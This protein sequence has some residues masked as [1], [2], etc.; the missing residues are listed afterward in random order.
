[1][2]LPASQGGLVVALVAAAASGPFNQGIYNGVIRSGPGIATALPFLPQKDFNRFLRATAE[3]A[4]PDTTVYPLIQF[5]A[6]PTAGSGPSFALP[7]DGSSGTIDGAVVYS[8]AAVGVDLREDQGPLDMR[9]SAADLVFAT[10]GSARR[11]RL[12]VLPVDRL[13]NPADPPAGLAVTVRVTPP[14]Q[15]AQPGPV[16]AEKGLSLLTAKG[17]RVTLK[18][19]AASASG[20][21]GVVTAERDGVVVA[22][23]SY[24]IDTRSNRPQPDVVVPGGNVPTIQ[25]AIEGASDDN[26]DGLIVIA[27]SPGIF[28]ENLIID[29]SVV[30]QG[31]GADRT[32]LQGDGTRAVVSVVAPNV[33]I[34]G[35]TAVGGT[36]GFALQG[37]STA[38]AECRAWHNDG[39]GVTVTGPSAGLWR[40][41]LIDNTGDGLVVQNANDLVCVGNT[42]VLNG[43]AGVR[44]V[45]GSGSQIEGSS[46]MSNTG[47]GVI[48][49]GAD[50]ATAH[51]NRS[52]L[53]LGSGIETSSSSRTQILA[54]LSATNDGD[55]LHM[56]GPNGDSVWD[57]VLEN[58]G[59]Y[60]LW[61]GG[62]MNA[63]FSAAPGTQP[64]IG[65]N[66]MVANQEGNVSLPGD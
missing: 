34:R 5:A 29:R 12:R 17:R 63:D 30:L 45:G 11:R 9:S 49:L 56:N 2:G 25:A 14:L 20:A 28:R 64:P 22:A 60:G 3:P 7:L 66:A 61:L 23:Q 44:I 41:G 53:N 15:I 24:R 21:T 48:V 58:N 51:R 13:G 62:S 39:A 6:L 8:Q 43:G 57:N 54:N 18:A 35:I 10:R 1:V 40:N 26:G 37:A 46:I 36:S 38:L 59:Q 55:G 32:I 4:G 47:S 19:S 16:S 65:S 52:I 31:A 42:A 50:L 33:T 27:V